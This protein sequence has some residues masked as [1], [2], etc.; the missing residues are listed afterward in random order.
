LFAVTL[1]LG[2]L[3]LVGEATARAISGTPWPEREPLL[4]VESNRGRGWAMQPGVHYTY[5]RLVHVNRFGLRGPPVRKKLPGERRVF[6]LGDSFVYGQGAAED[7]TIPARLEQALEA[8]SAHP[9]TVVNGGHRAYSTHQEVA[10]LRQI[11]PLIQPDDV[12]VLYFWNDFVEQDLKAQAIW[13][14]QNGPLAFDVGAP[15]EGWTRTRWHALQW[16]RRS[17]LV[18]WLYDRFRGPAPAETTPFSAVEYRWRFAERVR[19]LERV[20]GRIGCRLHFAIVPDPFA[21]NGPHLS[22]AIEAVVR[23]AL[24]EAG[25]EQIDLEGPLREWIGDGPLPVIPYDGHYLPEANRVM[26][27]VLAGA[28]AD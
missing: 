2:F 6:V 25:H 12:L 20:A 3:A 26:A 15:M 27:E 28:L 24:T 22:D 18:M 11:G 5:D 8:R 13:L 16:A 9:V 21:L 4:V 17:A 7:E 23:E 10:L 14:H 19:E 1:S